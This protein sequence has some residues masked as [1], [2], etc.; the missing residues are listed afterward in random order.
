[1]PILRVNAIGSIPTLADP[2]PK[3]PPLHDALKCHIGSG[4]VLIMLHGY[5]YSPSKHHLNP[6]EYILKNAT[7]LAQGQGQNWPHQMGYGTRWDTAPACPTPAFVS[8]SGGRQAAPSGAHS[9]KLAAQVWRL[10]P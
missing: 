7:D 4:P 8:R 9:A 5:R 2:R 6:H 3:H 10:H 1:M